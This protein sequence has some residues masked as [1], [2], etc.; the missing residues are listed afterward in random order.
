MIAIC[1]NVANSSVWNEIF[2][3]NNLEDINNILLSNYD[4]KYNGTKIVLDGT[5]INNYYLII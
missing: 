3:I 1:Y 5:Q 4:D 2:N